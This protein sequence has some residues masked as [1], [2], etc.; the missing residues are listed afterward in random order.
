MVEKLAYW[1]NSFMLNLPAAVPNKHY[2]YFYPSAFFLTLIIIGSA[3]IFW[4]ET[5]PPS[6]ATCWQ[7]KQDALL[8]QAQI[9]RDEIPQSQAQVPANSNEPNFTSMPLPSRVG[10]GSISA[11]DPSSWGKRLNASWYLDWNIQYRRVSQSPEHWQMIRLSNGCSFPP[12]G[13]LAWLVLHYPGQVW[14]I[15]NEPDVIWQDSVTP[16]EYARQYHDL[17]QI[18]KTSDPSAIIATAGIS[19]ATPLRLAYLDKVLAAYQSSYRQPMP[20]DWWTVHGYVLREERGSWGVDIPPGFS[21]N[22]GML[23]EVSDHGRIDLFEQQLI[24]FRQWMA[25]NGYRNTPLALTEFGI[26][27]PADYGFPTQFVQQYLMNTFRWLADTED[28]TIGLP[29]DGNHLVQR[30]AW[31]SLVDPKFPTS[32]LADLQNGRLSPV[33]ET[34]REFMLAN[35]H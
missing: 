20:V 13:S 14:I 7:A 24:A 15:G 26:L 6:T 19:Q 28:S 30:W 35:S 34:F 5:T 32:N 17:Y 1:Y 9:T 29:Q 11:L 18:I 3:V 27:M 25:N 16:E 23:Y 8:S 21:A 2:R 12:P 33:G 4:Q 10:F 31:F 22:T